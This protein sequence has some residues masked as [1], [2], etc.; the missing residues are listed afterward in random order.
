MVF[1]HTTERDAYLAASGKVILMACPGSGKTTTVAYKLLILINDWEKTKDKFSGIACLSFTNI[2]KDEINSKFSK[3]SGKDITFPHLVSTIDSFIN[4]YITLPFYY[5]FQNDFKERPKI[6]DDIT[7]LDSLNFRKYL[8]LDKG[9]RMPIM[10]RYKPS[11][12]VKEADDSFTFNHKKVIM[13]GSNAIIFQKY[14]NAIKEYQFKTGLLSNHDSTY[15]ALNILRKYPDIAKLLARRFPLLIIDEAQDTSGLQDAII[16]E[17]IKNFSIGVELV[18]DPYQ[19]L[20]EWRDAS[21]GLFRDKYHSP[22]WI[23]CDLT[24]CRRSTQIIVNCYSLVRCSADPLIR[25]QQIVA[26][27]ENIHIIVY[28]AGDEDKLIQEYKNISSSYEQRIIVVRGDSHLKAFK[29]KSEEQNLWK[30]EPNFP[31]ALI[32]AQ[33]DWKTGN[34]R[35]AV[36]QVRKCLPQL[37]D[38]SIKSNM[39]KQ[40]EMSAEIARIPEYNA[41]I[42]RM[43]A[44]MPS[45]DLDV[46][47]WTCKT[48]EKCHECFSLSERPNFELKEGKFRAFYGRKMSEVFQEGHNIN[49]V[50]TIHSVKGMT[51]ESLMLVLSK[52]SSAAN[53]SLND[54]TTAT[55]FLNEKQ[56]LIYVAMSR[57]KFQLVVAVPMDADKSDS[58]L[59]N[60]FGECIT[61]IRI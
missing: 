50:Q 7:F 44:E 39:Q 31:L 33:K 58:D 14:C 41:R 22:E 48:E 57:P 21:P 60:I 55:H 27:P 45:F 38:M 53:I 19:C 52:N 18:G 15:A 11:A 28:A 3:F 20:Y 8:I 42:V 9:K 32:R 16:T 2:A 49:F 25:S 36:I 29:A 35:K 51:F 17:L 43:I 12:I 40:A 30:I 47:E 4:Q 6:L 61:I 1:E 34:V 37:I 46:V 59:K 54:I 5:L 23:S 26:E 24:D 56:R 13:D 10:Y